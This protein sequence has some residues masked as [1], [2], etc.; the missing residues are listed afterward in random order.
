MATN[1]IR[2][3][4][5]GEILD[6]AFT[7]YRQRFPILMGISIVFLGV[8]TLLNVYVELSGGALEQGGLFLVAFILSSL[9]ALPAAAAI[10]SVVSEAALG[11]SAEL[12]SSIRRGLNR[13]VRLFVAGLAAY[14]LIALGCLA[15]VVPGIVIAC[16][17]SVVVQ[18]VVLED[19]ASG[20]DA[21]GRSWALT[22][23]Y[24][25]KAFKLALAF[26][27]LFFVPFMAAAVVASMMPALMVLFTVGA[28]IL[29]FVLTPLFSCVFTLFYYDL[30]VR[31]EGF[32]LEHLSRE[33]GL[34]PAARA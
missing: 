9:G 8:P 20:T 29:S 34:A 10:V 21:L 25:G 33:L 4:S 13:A 23:G 27:L 26:F 18:A 19:L 3:M 15:L 7:L 31:Q 17:Y 14:I 6:N 22:K 2:A 16:G 5:V 32:D 11:H 24:K 28:Q 1:A 30:R 12:G